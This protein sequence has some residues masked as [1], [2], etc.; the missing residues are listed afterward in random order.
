MKT[1]PKKKK[2]QPLKCRRNQNKR[3]I[4]VEQVRTLLHLQLEDVAR[5]LNLSINTIQRIQ[6]ELQT[7]KTEE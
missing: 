7:T 5:E 1:S 3:E 6:V 2:P 4:I